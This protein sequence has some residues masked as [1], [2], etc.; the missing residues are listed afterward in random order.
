MH[1]EITHQQ[2]GM[3]E[4]ERTGIYPEYLLFNRPGTRQ[5]WRIRIKEKPQEGVLK[6]KGKIVYHYSFDGDFCKTRTVNEDGSLSNW[7][8][9]KIMIT[10]MRD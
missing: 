8:E 5:S 7:I 2:G 3:R 6:S 4:F 1:L 10:E 9:P